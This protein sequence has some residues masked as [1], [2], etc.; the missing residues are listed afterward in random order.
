MFTFFAVAS[1]LL[2]WRRKIYTGYKGRHHINRRRDGR[3][4]IWVGQLNRSLEMR[5][6]WKK[7]GSLAYKRFIGEVPFPTRKHV[8]IYA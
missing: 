2:N 5:I 7:K 8:R 3:R 4:N 6:Y 1:L